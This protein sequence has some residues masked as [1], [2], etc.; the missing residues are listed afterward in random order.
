MKLETERLILRTWTEADMDSFVE[1]SA[2]LEIMQWLGGVLTAEQA[3]A[4]M[5]RANHSFATRRMGRFVLERKQDGRFIGSCGLMP[6]VETL[7]I[8]PYIDM[9][10][11]LAR[12]A[13]GHGFAT[14][15]AAAVLRDGF[16][17]LKFE[18]I[19]AITAETNRRS[20]AVMERLGMTRDAASDF[21]HPAYDGDEQQG[22]T[23]VYRLRRGAASVP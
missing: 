17:R 10:W 15:A 9:G 11:R 21:S 16:E 13:W 2:D 14:E 1:M 19:T 7:P 20:R 4:Y 6:G 23:V 12:S 5:D 22:R 18:E 8:A 3:R